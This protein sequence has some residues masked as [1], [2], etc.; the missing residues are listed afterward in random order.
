MIELGFTGD[1]L[2]TP[3]MRHAGTVYI[4]DPGA[5][6]WFATIPGAVR[7]EPRPIWIPGKGPDD[8]YSVGAVEQ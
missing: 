1:G 7:F 6:T 8:R 4:F 5:R 2:Q 3:A